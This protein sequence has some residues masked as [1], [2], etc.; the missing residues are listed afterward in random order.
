MIFYNLTVRVN[1]KRL[2]AVIGALEGLEIVS[3]VKDQETTAQ[4]PS[5]V[6]GFRH[7]TKNG[8]EKTVLEALRK[9]P[10]KGLSLDEIKNAL[11]AVGFAE[12][13]AAAAVSRLARTGR[14]SKQ[15]NRIWLASH[16]RIHAT[17]EGRKR[18]TEQ[19]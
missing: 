10:Q 7:R 2:G 5:K 16:L 12:T 14:V 15:N 1:E 11:T 6:P 17:G 8:T 3:V 4:P 13:S 18:D 19:E 9:D